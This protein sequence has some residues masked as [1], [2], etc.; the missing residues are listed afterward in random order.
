MDPHVLTMAQ[1]EGET[2]SQRLRLLMERDVNEDQTL[3]G[4]G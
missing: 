2:K 3:T 1:K 4:E